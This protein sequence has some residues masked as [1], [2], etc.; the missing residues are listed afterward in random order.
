MKKLAYLLLFI[1]LISNQINNREHDDFISFQKS[2]QGFPNSYKTGDTLTSLD[3]SILNNDR[4]IDTIFLIRYQ[5]IDT[6]FKTIYK[7]QTLSGYN[8][9]F[10]GRYNNKNS[11]LI[12]TYSIKTLSDDGNPML[13]L[14]N[15]S[16]DGKLLGMIRTDLEY[17]HD[18]ELRPITYFSISP[19]FG[20]Y[21]NQ[22]E[23]RYKFDNDEY[24]LTDSSSVIMKYKIGSDGKFLL[25]SK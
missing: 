17:E 22:V 18:P 25:K 16:N 14:S 21:I 7:P 19:D 13:T 11:F 8:C 2:L 3:Y 4:F 12:L 1:P 6:S 24:H 5:L 23:K 15:F 9:T 20:I 10:I